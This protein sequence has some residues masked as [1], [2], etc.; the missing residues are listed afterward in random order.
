MAIS[1]PTLSF[2]QNTTMVGNQYLVHYLILKKGMENFFPLN[3]SFLFCF[4]NSTF[5]ATIGRWYVSINSLS[6][7]INN[8]SWHQTALWLIM[9]W[10]SLIWCKIRVISQSKNLDRC[11]YDNVLN[12]A[13]NEYIWYNK[14]KLNFTTS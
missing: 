7:R 6:T 10:K 12:P 8:I 2:I 9:I 4:S 14:F 5:K 11:I 1:F 3:L 13:F